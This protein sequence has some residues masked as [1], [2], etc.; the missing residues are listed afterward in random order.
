MAGLDRARLVAYQPEVL[1]EGPR[2]APDTTLISEGCRQRLCRS[3]VVKR[4]AQVTECV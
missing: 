1:C 3:E 2:D 4:L